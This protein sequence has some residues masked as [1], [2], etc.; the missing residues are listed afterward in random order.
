[1]TLRALHQIVPSLRPHD[2]VGDHT[3]RLRE[4]L[5]GAGL[6]SEIFSD[7]VHPSLRSEGQPL[8]AL[9]AEDASGSTALLYQ[10]SIGNPV[11]DLLLRRPEPIVVNY[12]NL[13]PVAQLLRWEPDM[14]HLVGWGRSQLA[15]LAPRAVLGVGDSDYNT[16]ELRTAGFRS[17]ETAPILLEL[18]EPVD[19]EVEPERDRSWLFVGRVV[20]NKAQHDL[21]AAFAWYRRHHDP[22]ARLCMI[23]SDTAPRYRAALD[24]MIERLALGDAVQLRSGVADDQLRR[25]YRTA[26]VFVCLSDH[27]G[28]CI[29]LLEAMAHGLPVVAHAAAAVPET[30]GG[31]GLLLPSK[32]PVL[33]AAAAHRVLGDAALR[34]RLTIDG[35]ARVASFSAATTARRHLD[36]LASVLDLPTYADGRVTDPQQ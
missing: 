27:E 7:D 34:Q 25:A 12:H 1:M 32:D 16:A 9:P 21:I 8:V 15:A 18:E 28:F 10:L 3:R 23:G 19:Q 26:G 20:P 33:V 6:Q 4:V 5:R 30:V 24:R 17:C 22:T 36:A 31:A 14:A 29:P 13:T 35:R 11:V 2:A